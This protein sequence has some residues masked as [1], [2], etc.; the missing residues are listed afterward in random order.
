MLLNRPYEII[1]RS[2]IWQQ[3]SVDRRTVQT[4]SACAQKAAR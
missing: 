1:I 3:H 4:R 2:K